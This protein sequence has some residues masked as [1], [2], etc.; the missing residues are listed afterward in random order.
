MKISGYFGDRFRGGNFM[1]DQSS[2]VHRCWEAE[3]R[4]FQRGTGLGTRLGPGL[5]DSLRHIREN[6]LLVY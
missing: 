5:Q 1:V 2:L 6:T 4:Q 3:Q